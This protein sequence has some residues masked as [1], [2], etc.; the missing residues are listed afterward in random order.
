VTPKGSRH[1]QGG[2]IYS[3]FYGSVKEVTDLAKL[4]PFENDGLEE[5]ALDTQIRLGARQ[6]IGGNWR[7]I[8]VLKK[9]YCVS[10]KSARNYIEASQRKSFGIREEH[11]MSWDLF[12]GLKGRVEE[13]EGDVEEGSITLLDCPSYMWSVQTRV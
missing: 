1:R 13:E 4:M 5:L 11:R 6:V 12:E 3:Q 2:L 10:K 8:S 7:D 9:A